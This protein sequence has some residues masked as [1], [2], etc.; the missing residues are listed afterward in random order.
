MARQAYEGCHVLQFGHGHGVV[1]FLFVPAFG[2]RRRNLSYASLQLDDLFHVLLCS[3]GIGAVQ[4]NAHLTT[5]NSSQPN[6]S[7]LFP[8][9]CLGTGTMNL[10]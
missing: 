8:E 5:E 6:H 7:S 1:E 2:R 3:I 10:Y 9:T 4:Q